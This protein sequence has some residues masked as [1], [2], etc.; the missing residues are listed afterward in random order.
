MRFRNAN[1]LAAV[2]CA[3]LSAPAAHAISVKA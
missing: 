1:V 2:L 3:A